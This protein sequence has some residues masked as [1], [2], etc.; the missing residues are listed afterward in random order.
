MFDQLTFTEATDREKVDRSVFLIGV[1]ESA[2]TGDVFGMIADAG[3]D[4]GAI[5]MPGKS[6]VRLLHL[7]DE[8]VV[9]QKRGLAN[10]SP[11]DLS[12]ERAEQKISQDRMIFKGL[13]C[14]IAF[15]PVIDPKDVGVPAVHLRIHLVDSPRAHLPE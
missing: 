15:A 8:L 9:M 5:L 7:D 2:P 6:H 4:I 11:A 3:L 10:R 12:H 14:K 13:A 1:I